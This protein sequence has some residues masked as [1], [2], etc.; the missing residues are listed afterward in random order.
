MTDIDKNNKPEKI[1][2]MSDAPRDGSKFM[3]VDFNG[4]WTVVEFRPGPE[5]FDWFD[6][7]EGASHRI[8]AYEGFL[9]P[10]P[11]PNTQQAAKVLLDSED[12]IHEKAI[13]RGITRLRPYGGKPSDKIKFEAGFVAALRA[14][15]EQEQDT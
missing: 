15:A 2:P 11:T 13:S 14:I 1:S 8:E 7:S 9:D 6:F 4:D 12:A 10:R 5:G 3:A